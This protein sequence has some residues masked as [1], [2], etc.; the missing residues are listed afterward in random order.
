MSVSYVGGINSSGSGQGILLPAY[1]PA[2]TNLLV[3]IVG[4]FAYS[5]GM[6]LFQLSMPGIS[7]TADN[8]WETIGASPASEWVYG[9]GFESTWQLYAFYVRRAKPQYTVVGVNLPGDACNIAVALVEYSGLNAALP[10]DMFLF[11]EAATGT[12]TNSVDTGTITITDPPVLLVSACFDNGNGAGVAQTFTPSAG[13]TSR[14]TVT[15]ATN[16]LN[17]RVWDQTTGG[18]SAHNLVSASVP[19]D[20]MHACVIAFRETTIT[21]MPIVQSGYSFGLPDGT[22][23]GKAVYPFAFP[24]TSGNS[25]ICAVYGA[26]DAP[27]DLLGND[28]ELIATLGNFFIYFVAKCIGG[29]NVITVTGLNGIGAEQ[30][31]IIAVETFPATYL[32]GAQDSTPSGVSVIAGPIS[33]QTGDLFLCLGA[34]QAGSAIGT[35]QIIGEP[36]YIQLSQMSGFGPNLADI[37]GGTLLYHVADGT[38]NYGVNISVASA[39]NLQVALIGFRITYP[40]SVTQQTSLLI[41]DNANMRWRNYSYDANAIFYEADTNKLLM[42]TSE[43]EGYAIRYLDYIDYNDGGWSPSIGLVQD[44]ITL[45]I[46][47]PEE[48]MKQPHLPKQWNMVEVDVNTKGQD[49]TVVLNFDDGITPLNIGKVNTVQRQ[50]FQLAV[51]DGKGQESYKCSPEIHMQ[52][53]VAPIIYQLNVYAALLAAN[54]STYDTY[55][56]KFN[57]DFSKL[58]KEGYFD[59][60]ST[61]EIEVNLYA[62]GN[63]VPY[64]TFFLPAN[65]TRF[66]VPMRVRFPAVSCRLWR[67]VMES[68]SGSILLDSAP[69]QLWNAPT[70][71]WKERL[72]G[73]GYARE[74]LTI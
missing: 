25:I 62:D 5:P 49:L 41:W 46:Q 70:I 39:V 28:Y 3:L 57:T 60:T 67:L 52:V 10:L 64:Y 8:K 36:D 35:Q 40:S 29:N 37:W 12:L 73:S 72:V 55:W 15:D 59:Y 7:D 34:E 65:P 2:S 43:P 31:P 45:D 51:N 24:N 61:T 26:S 48:D 1:K 21:P 58:I 44:P 23:A 38:A 19:S 74:D 16:S 30:S 14:Q 32:A 47:L 53:L 63:S 69:F 6:T 56:I 54:R 22:N 11:N 4:V 17:L 13:Y 20:G 9:S 50:K 33:G 18:N 68:F 71:T 66:E 42:A 27:A